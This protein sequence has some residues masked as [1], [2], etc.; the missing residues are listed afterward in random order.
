MHYIIHCLD[1]AG[2]LP[3]R[4]AHYDAHK[5]YLAQPAVDIVVSG[6]LLAPDGETMIGSFFLVEADSM[7]KV[8]SFHREDPFFAAGI[9]ERAEI[10]PFSKRMDN[11]A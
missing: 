3:V 4:L 5:A 7:A 10:H 6:P 1:K 2:A 9:W 11:R 8:Q